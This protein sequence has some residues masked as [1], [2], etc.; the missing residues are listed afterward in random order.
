MDNTP[1]APQISQPARE[2]IAA[3]LKRLRKERQLSQERMA[4]LAGFHRTYVSQLER[5]VTNISIDGLERL[6][7]ALGVDVQAL[8]APFIPCE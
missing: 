4:E 5:C 6:A 3:N 2:R 7:S 8:L 1:Q